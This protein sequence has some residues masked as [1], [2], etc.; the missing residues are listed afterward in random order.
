MSDD[1]SSQENETNLN[2]SGDTVLGRF[3]GVKSKFQRSLKSI[4][5]NE[6]GEKMKVISNI[7]AKA[8]EKYT[9][10]KDELGYQTSKKFLE[11]KV[12]VARYKAYMGLGSGVLFGASA[13]IV[14]RKFLKSRPTNAVS[15][16]VFSFCGFPY[17][18]NWYI[19]RRELQDFLLKNPRK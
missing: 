3:Q 11:S 6:D 12:E 14:A 5:K 15:L 4:L 7:S 17:S 9:L 18:Y 16:V 8:K 10:G 2:K 1:K 13:H 19:K